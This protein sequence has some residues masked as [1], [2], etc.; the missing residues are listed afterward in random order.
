MTEASGRPEALS[1][2]LKTLFLEEVERASNLMNMKPVRPLP[3]SVVLVSLPIEKG[4]RSGV[5]YVGGEMRVS[6]ELE[7]R[8]VRQVLRREA[9][10]TL[11]PRE[12]DSLP[13]TIDLAWAYSRADRSWWS[14]CT[15][16][17]ADPPFPD[18]DAPKIFSSVDDIEVENVVRAV[19][20]ALKMRILLF[21]EVDFRSYHEILLAA[22]GAL[23]PPRLTGSE[24]AV[25]EAL[26]RDPYLDRAGLKMVTGLSAASISRALKRLRG[27]R[28]I[29]GPQ[30]VVYGRIGLRSALVEVPPSKSA[31]TRELLRFPFTYSAFLPL[32]P[33]A[34]AYFVLL[35]PTSHLT[36]LK[37]VLSDSASLSLIKRHAL[38]TGFRRLDIRGALEGLASAYDRG[39]KRSRRPEPVRKPVPRISRQDI[40]LMNLVAAEGRVS[41]S[42]ASSAGIRSAEDRLRRLKEEKV[43][44]EFYTIG[45]W[46]LGEPIAVK[47]DLPESE[48]LR[49]FK[50]L[51]ALGSAV[52]TYVE[53]DFTGVWG[54]VFVDP[55]S[56][57]A[58]ARALRLA[59]GDRLA[60]LSLSTSVPSSSWRIPVELWD[61]EAQRFRVGPLIERLRA[62][63]LKAERLT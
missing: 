1:G 9:L 44:M 60:G 10:L 34:P 2:R 16:R 61:E 6:S 47:L 52:V 15:R 20:H 40:E 30:Q 13:E 54:V 12:L 59:F 7:E 31:L 51:S 3:E 18:Y 42:M 14:A 37:A 24:R 35:F 27:L 43:I 32:E 19:L 46:G 55:S 29:E 5:Q 63:A 38:S 62:A 23:E 45:G 57:V 36:Q 49:A 11:Y 58:V 53:G 8:R 33:S 26:G 21:G 56:A 25:L 41:I 48:Y 17:R 28:M 4:Y 39:P 50:S 22:A